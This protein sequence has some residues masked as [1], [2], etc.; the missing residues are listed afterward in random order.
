MERLWAG[1][2]FA[3]LGIPFAVFPEQLARL[4][5]WRFKNA[6]P[7]D[8]A[9]AVNRIVGIVLILFGLCFAFSKNLIR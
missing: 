5:T 8:A 7:S 9:I 2:V 3:L 4:G 1:L 6:E